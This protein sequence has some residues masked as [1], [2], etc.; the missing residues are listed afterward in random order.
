MN[1]FVAFER[2]CDLMGK[3]TTHVLD[4]HSGRPAGGVRIELRTLAGDA[5]QLI[6]NYVTAD[7]GRCAQNLLEDATFS[8]GRYE[9]TFHIADYFRSR[10]V[11]IPEPAFIDAAVIRIGIADASQH[12]HVP[13]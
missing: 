13:C 11:P 1:R 2:G 9:L 8:Q 12:Y 6:G 3:L 5:S 10:G 7:N 4:T